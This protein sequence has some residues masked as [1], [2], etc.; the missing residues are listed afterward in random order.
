MTEITYFFGAGASN[1]SMPLVSNFAERFEIF[2]RY[3]NNKTDLESVKFREELINFSENIKNHLSFD[4]YFKKLFHQG[5]KEKIASS[6]ILLLTYFVFEHIVNKSTHSSFYKRNT[7]P[8]KYNLDPRYDALI[9]GLLKPNEGVFDFY[10]KINF[11]TW[12]YDLNLINSIR[13][14][15]RTQELSLDT[16]IKKTNTSENEFTFENNT[17]LFHLNGYAYFPSVKQIKEENEQNL[18]VMIKELVIKYFNKDENLIEYAMKINFSWETT[19]SKNTFSAEILQRASKSIQKS[20]YIIIIGY[21]FPLYNRPIDRLLLSPGNL[22]E[23]QIIIQNP[24]AE[25]QSKELIDLFELDHLLKLRGGKTKIIPITN[26]NSFFV[27][28]DLF[29]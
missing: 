16:F 15:S 6:K 11:I 14:F 22:S 24:D 19:N 1:L 18:M 10:C 25:N 3:F 28:N 8:K 7:I 13:N 27:P 2:I 9:A 29:I 20:K 5:E 26:C 17:N 4:T 21:S 12:N 23:K